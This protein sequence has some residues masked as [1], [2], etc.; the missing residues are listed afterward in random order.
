MLET[1][2]LLHEVNASKAEV[3]EAYEAFAKCTLLLADEVVKKI[4]ERGSVVEM[5]GEQLIAYLE[6]AKRLTEAEDK[7]TAASKSLT[8]CLHS[9]RQET[10]Q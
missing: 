5:F 1:N 6:A 8:K 4:G 7:A 9:I 10:A 2:E 3:E